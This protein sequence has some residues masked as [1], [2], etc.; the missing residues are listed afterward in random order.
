MS[1]PLKRTALLFYALVLTGC[2]VINLTPLSYS[3]DQDKIYVTGVID[4]NSL[5]SFK[6]AWRAAPNAKTLVLQSVPGSFDDDANLEFSQFIHDNGFNT[7]VPADG[8]IASGGTDLFLA[9]ISRI[10]ESGACVGVHSWGTDFGVQGRDLKRDHKIHEPYLNYYRAIG[11]DEDFY[12]YTLDIATADDMHWMSASE[13]R[14]Y[15]MT[16]TYTGQLSG[17]ETCNKG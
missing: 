5:E 16:T 7:L 15:K 6:K 17:K 10:I 12:W 13:T 14:R 8:L 11:I 3:T 4:A 1:L 2:D 9:G